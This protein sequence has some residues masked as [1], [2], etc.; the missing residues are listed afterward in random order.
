ML[1]ASNPDFLKWF[2]SSNLPL[3]KSYSYEFLHNWLGGGLLISAGILTLFEKKN[4]SIQFPNF[5]VKSGRE[6]GKY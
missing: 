5:Q 3:A 2:L 6:A 4:N 1:M